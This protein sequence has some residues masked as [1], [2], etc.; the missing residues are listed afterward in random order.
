MGLIGAMSYQMSQCPFEIEIGKVIMGQFQKAIESCDHF[1]K[2][3]T[4]LTYNL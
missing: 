2:A 4:I 3:E 1:K